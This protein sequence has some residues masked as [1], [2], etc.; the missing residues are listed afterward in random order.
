MRGPPQK[1]KIMKTR[2]IFLGGREDPEK[3]LISQ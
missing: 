3:E 2:T 1:R